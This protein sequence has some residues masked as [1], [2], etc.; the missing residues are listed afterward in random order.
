M[1]NIE[2][3]NL[4]ISAIYPID[5]QLSLTFCDGG[6][7]IVTSAVS[8]LIHIFARVYLNKNIVTLSS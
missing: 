7:S 6:I 2:T 3:K 4:K 1:S 8:Q 5:I